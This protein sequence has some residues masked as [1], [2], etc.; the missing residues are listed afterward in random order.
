MARAR[1]VPPPSHPG[2]RWNNLRRPIRPCLAR[3]TQTKPL[4]GAC[5][6]ATGGHTD[7]PAWVVAGAP[8]D[9]ES[10]ISPRGPA[11]GAPSRAVRQACLPPGGT[12]GS[13]SGG[14]PAATLGHRRSARMPPRNQR[15]LLASCPTPFTD[16]ELERLARPLSRINTIPAWARPKVSTKAREWSLVA[17]CFRPP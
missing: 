4:S 14:T 15:T 12:P 3:H 16:S 7:T 5:P 9:V 11:S 6:K 2:Q 13:T 17:S 8:P 10:G 1:V